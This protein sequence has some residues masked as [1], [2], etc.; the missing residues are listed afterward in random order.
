MLPVV[1]ALEAWTNS[2]GRCPGGPR[3]QVVIA[4][5]R[6]ASPESLVCD[7]TVPLA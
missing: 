4:D 5:Q 2:H 7:L 3:R 6:T 1:E